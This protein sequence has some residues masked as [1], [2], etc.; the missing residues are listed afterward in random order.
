MDIVHSKLHV[1]DVNA[2]PRI[3]ETSDGFCETFVKLILAAT[4]GTQKMFCPPNRNSHI[5]SDA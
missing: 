2:A 5:S 3:S 1:L 4:R